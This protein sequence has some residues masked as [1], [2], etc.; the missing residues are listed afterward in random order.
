MKKSAL[1]FLLLLP[2]VALSARGDNGGVNKIRGIY[3]EAK[4]QIAMGDEEV[5]ARNCV[6]MHGQYMVP[7][8]GPTDDVIRCYFRL[9][10]VDEGEMIYQPY[11]ITRTHNVAARNYYDEWLFDEDG[12]LVFCYEKSG[13][14]EVRYYWCD[15]GLVTVGGGEWLTDA[16]SAQSEAQTIQLSFAMIMNRRQ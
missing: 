6:E 14:D 8:C 2:L 13:D 10:Y 12:M 11:F 5:Q 7:G 1:I 3:N 16:L 9:Q 4:H 15:S